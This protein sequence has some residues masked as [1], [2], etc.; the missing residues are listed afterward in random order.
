[1]SAKKKKL[2]VAICF[3]LLALLMVLVLGRDN[4]PNSLQSSD[5]VATNLQFT[6]EL[7]QS[8]GIL[9][10]HTGTAVAKLDLAKP[11]KRF[12]SILLTKDYP[13]NE[14][15]RV[16]RG[17]NFT[18]VRTN[19]FA[20]ENIIHFNNKGA[21]SMKLVDGKIW[22]VI[23][24]DIGASALPVNDPSKISDAIALEDTIYF[25]QNVEGK[26]QSL[27]SLDI[28][29]YRPT[30]I[31]KNL[32]A[33][34]II[35][36]TG[37]RLILRDFG[38][39]VF[40][41]SKGTVDVVAEGVGEAYHDPETDSLVYTKNGGNSHG[42]EGGSVSV[43]TSKSQQVTVRRLSDSKESQVDLAS[44]GFYVSR[45]YLVG[46]PKLSQ[47]DHV[48]IY[49]IRDGVRHKIKI[50]QSESKVTNQIKM[51]HVIKDD[52]SL[53]AVVT[54]N[55]QLVL[56]GSSKYINDTSYVVSPKIPVSIS[57][58]GL[59]RNIATN[60]LTIYYPPNQDSEEIIKRSIGY[61]SNSC[62]CDINQL[63]KRWLPTASEPG[64]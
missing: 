46:V 32:D 49:R 16:S 39:N 41:V 6:R 9:N 31:A 30:E 64:H 27:F 52:L 62:E 24:D 37:E 33:S 47:P 43:G 8:N 34:S 38:G 15:D 21:N 53:L 50:D 56:Y 19:Y 26:K 28:K 59:E 57:E 20:D 22:V 29:D 40:Q 12:T 45:G 55:N 54:N 13:L 14:V 17:D 44:T 23:E 42:E 18:L 60:H 48:L 25:L 35:G 5:I 1:M 51:M 36:G 4:T 3:G 58:Y 11:K 7:S 61:I 2:I 10:F 63:S